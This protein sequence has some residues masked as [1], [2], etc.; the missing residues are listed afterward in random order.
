M[1]LIWRQSYINLF[2]KKLH[3]NKKKPSP[4][5]KLVIPYDGSNFYSIAYSAFNI[6]YYNDTAVLYNAYI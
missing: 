3:R 5:Q 1:K 2:K 6:S 4:I